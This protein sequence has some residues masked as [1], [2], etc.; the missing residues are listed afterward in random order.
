MSLFKRE[1]R[2]NKTL[3]EQTLRIATTV[4]VTLSLAISVPSIGF[5][6]VNTIDKVTDS[7][8]TKA[9]LVI[10]DT[11][12]EIDSL[13]SE[14]LKVKEH[15][16]AFD[17]N[18]SI[19]SFIKAR[20]KNNANIHGYYIINSDGTISATSEDIKKEI[21]GYKNLD[22]FIDSIRTSKSDLNY[23]DKIY[24]DGLIDMY[25][26]IKSEVNGNTKIL[27]AKVSLDEIVEKL[28]GYTEEKSYP[29]LIDEHGD[30]LYHILYGPTNEAT[31][32]SDAG[33]EELLDILKTDGKVGS[34]YKSK[35]GNRYFITKSTLP[36]NWNIVYVTSIWYVL[37]SVIKEIAILACIAISVCVLSLGIL[38]RKLKKN[39]EPIKIISDHINKLSSGDLSIEDMDINAANELTELANGINYLVSSLNGVISTA[40]NVADTAYYTSKDLLKAGEDTAKSAEIIAN[41]ITSVSNGI[42]EQTENTLSTADSLDSLSVE[43]KNIFNNIKTT[44]DNMDN[45]LVKAKDGGYIVDELL[46]RNNDINEIMTSVKDMVNTFIE[47]VNHIAVISSDIEEISSQTNLLSLNAAIE[48]ARAGIHGQGFAVVADEIRKLSDL[49]ATSNKKVSDISKELVNNIIDIELKTKESMV[50]LD[51]QNKS[52]NASRDTFMAISKD[53]KYVHNLVEGIKQS[54]EKAS[55]ETAKVTDSL[56]NISAVSQENS[57]HTEEIVAMTEEQLA[58]SEHLMETVIKLNEICN[59]LE[60]TISQFKTK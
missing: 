60:K 7:N 34:F 8:N 24:K 55:D 54:M 28:K 50:S 41:T 56:N 37:D 27:I 57:S 23:G 5:F 32:I 36:N 3:Q 47:S 40:K 45:T 21:G 44:I 18:E 53:I 38:R 16:K 2:N 14:L 1:K 13:I 29:Y 30:I 52:V 35:T 10:H 25:V 59:K 11:E 4:V 46:E 19:S 17:D 31:N 48:A 6:T 20:V 58:E 15:I 33:S 51:S 42:S 22:K 39:L 9:D 26:G 43:I 49:T 12:K